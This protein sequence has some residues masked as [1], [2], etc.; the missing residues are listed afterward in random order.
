MSSPPNPSFPLPEIP[1]PPAVLGDLPCRKCSYNLRTLST[2][3]LCPECGTPVAL[4]LQRDL[5]A[6]SDPKWVG[7]L[8]LGM[9]LAQWCTIPFALAV[10]ANAIWTARPAYLSMVSIFEICGIIQIT[11]GCWL[12][13]VPDPSGI[14]EPGYG[15]L[16]GAT[17]LISLVWVAEAM[18]DCFYGFSALPAP[19]DRLLYFSLG[20][21]LGF[22]GI[23]GLYAPLRYLGKLSH[24]IP[25]QKLARRMA[26]MSY[27]IPICA[28]LCRAS[29]IVSDWLNSRRM[30]APSNPQWG[31]MLPFTMAV[32]IV[33]IL[34]M[35]FVP[36]YVNRLVA[37]F[38]EQT[39]LAKKAWAR[40]PATGELKGSGPFNNKILH[41]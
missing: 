12:F 41:K 34:P 33:T 21:P 35:Q 32:G 28:C 39:A 8:F 5:L 23:I 11:I 16:R 19:L 7:K 17:R 13:T 6:S 38:K 29:F 30:I 10:F 36:Y 4:S 3:G 9:R 26:L 18:L 22:A 24:R 1:P 2:D 27:V 40:E 31:K 37:H 14:G 20:G 25:D 15:R